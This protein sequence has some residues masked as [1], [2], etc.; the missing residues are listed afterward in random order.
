VLASPEA[1]ED[2]VFGPNGLA[3]GL[4]PGTA[5][6]DMSTVGPNAVQ[7]VAA[8]LGEGIEVLDA[9][10]LGSVPEAEEGSLKVF[11]GGTEEAFDR[12]QLVLSSFGSVR[13][14]GRLGAGASMKLA[15]NSTLVAL[16]TALAE[17]LA[18]GDALG[19]DQSLVLDI[20]ADSP[21]GVPARSKR[22]RIESGVYP[23][24]FKV[25]LAA[26][27]ASLVVETAKAA[28]LELPLAAAGRDWMTGAA[29]AGLGDLDYSAVVA[30]ARRRPAR[31]PGE[32]PAGPDNGST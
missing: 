31:L 23:P 29:E 22:S 16:M 19:L 6:I 24:N 26:K 18:L 11:V 10:V 2:V 14:V 3:H 15:V 7:D 4:A 17:A 1:L 13:H 32:P 21:I 8:R 20:L 12:W 25:A 28:G 9:P 30:H 5:L 27:D